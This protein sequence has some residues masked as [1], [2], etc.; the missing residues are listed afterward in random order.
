[1]IVLHPI[2]QTIII[3]T[4]CH[5]IASTCDFSLDGVSL[6]PS[7]RF[8]IAAIHR[9]NVELHASLGVGRVFATLELVWYDDA[10]YVLCDRGLDRL[11]GNDQKC[12]GPFRGGSMVGILVLGIQ[13]VGTSNTKPLT[14]TQ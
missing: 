11:L 5:A 13:V 7:F 2:H 1:M 4:E 10:M 12:F 3:I 14:D 6:H 9:R 8:D